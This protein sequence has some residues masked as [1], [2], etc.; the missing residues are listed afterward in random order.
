MPKIKAS[1]LRS[2]PKG[3][4]LKQL[5]DLK[6]ELATVRLRYPCPPSTP[7]TSEA[8]RRLALQPTSPPHRRPVVS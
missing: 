5:D 4:L 3:E 8:A 6:K 1:D 7:S 2:K